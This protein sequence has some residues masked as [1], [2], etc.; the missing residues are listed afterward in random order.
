MSDRL[1]LGR[2]AF[3]ALR[4]TGLILSNH[5]DSWQDKNHLQHKAAEAPTFAALAALRQR[6]GL[7]KAFSHVGATNLAWLLLVSFFCTVLPVL[8]RNVCV[9]AVMFFT[10]FYVKNSIVSLCFSICLHVCLHMSPVSHL[11]HQPIIRSMS[12]APGTL[13]PFQVDLRPAV[14]QH[15]IEQQKQRKDAKSTI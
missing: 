1:Y 6:P 8:P 7:G 2:V 15:E 4:L 12:Q 10:D 11:K 13:V 3:V 14:A 9:C 5:C